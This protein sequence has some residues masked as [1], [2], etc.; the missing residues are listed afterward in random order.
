MVARR[1]VM[2]V[3]FA[4]ALIVVTAAY[5]DR[6][7]HSEHLALTP[8]GDAPLRS[9]F[10]ENIHANGPRVYAHEVYALN[11]ATPRTSY[12]VTLLLHPLDPTCSGS[13]VEVPEITLTTN[14]AGN[15]VGVNTFDVATVDAFGIRHATHGISWRFV[16]T[17]GDTYVTACSAVT[18][19]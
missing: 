13:A 9:G 6:V 14:A 2:L 1:L 8:V 5:G 11:G 4:A 15:A 10:V 7:Y 12:D 17:N 18:L 16:G 3:W 19:D